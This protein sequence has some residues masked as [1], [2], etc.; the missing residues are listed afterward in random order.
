MMLKVKNNNLR[1]KII[2]FLKK[3][4]GTK[5]APDAIKWHLHY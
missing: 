2:S 4:I 1:S 3:K 5:N